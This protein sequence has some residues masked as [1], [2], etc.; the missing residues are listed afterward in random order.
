[1]ASQAQ[2]HAP[3]EVMSTMM[4]VPTT[5]ISLHVFSIWRFDPQTEG[6]RQAFPPRA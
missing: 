1:L 5:L 6:V 3:A 4:S 2:P